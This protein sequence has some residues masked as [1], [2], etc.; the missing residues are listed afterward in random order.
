[1]LGVIG[2]GSSP[3]CGVRNTLGL[4][5][6]LEVIAACP[7]AAITRAMINEHVLVGCRIAGEGLFIRQLRLRLDR[8]G[9][10]LPF[11]E[12]DIVAEMRRQPQN[13]VTGLK[14]HDHG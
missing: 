7:V 1:M 9:I 3:S 13:P 14:Q 10:S 8:K 6:C 12:Y 11:D 4:P 5:R 2:V